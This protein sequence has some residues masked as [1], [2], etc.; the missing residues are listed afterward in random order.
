VINLLGLMNLMLG[1]LNPTE[2]AIMDRALWE[3]YAKKDITPA[4][5]LTNVEVPTMQDLVEVLGGMVGGE[6]LAQRL[7]KYTEGTFS[8]IFNQPTN[9][10]LNNQ[11][12]VFSVRDLEDSLRPIAIYVTLNYLWNIV[13]SL[14]K[15][16]LVIDEAWWM[17]QHEDSAQVF[18][19]HGQTRP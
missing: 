1:K 8:G 17:M 7:T 19:W 11:L 16:I 9:I 3:T 18:V 5:N 4:S 2:E 12:V 15:R 6:S 14:K 13:R 10:N